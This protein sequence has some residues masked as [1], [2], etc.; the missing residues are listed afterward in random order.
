MINIALKIILIISD[1]R[2]VW[3]RFFSRKGPAVHPALVKMHDRSHRRK[4]SRLP[5][6]CKAGKDDFAPLSSAS[7]L[8]AFTRI[9]LPLDTRSSRHSGSRSQQLL[10]FLAIQWS[11]ILT[12]QWVLSPLA[13]DPWRKRT[14]RMGLT[15]TSPHLRSATILNNRQSLSKLT[16]LLHLLPSASQSSS[17]CSYTST[18]SSEGISSK[19]P[20]KTF[21]YVLSSRVHPS[22]HIPQ[23]SLRHPSL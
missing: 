15:A 19:S 14:W 11:C 1:R 4:V 20:W 12:L 7:L 18:S 6:W 21:S 9:Y 22:Y 2:S 10:V 23:R 16:M 5:S 17:S 3:K 8:A 13:T